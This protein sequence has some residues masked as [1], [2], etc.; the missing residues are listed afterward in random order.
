MFTPSD[1][2]EPTVV[3]VCRLVAGSTAVRA[4]RVE[5]NCRPTY[6]ELMRFRE[7]AQAHDLTMIVLGSGGICLRSRSVTACGDS[8]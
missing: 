3:A 6:V 2:L 5:T 8:L 7:V 4:I 1:Q